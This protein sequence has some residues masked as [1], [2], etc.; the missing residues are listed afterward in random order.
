MKD[1]E[2][3]SQ[4]SQMPVESEMHVRNKKVYCS[5]LQLLLMMK[6]DNIKAKKYLLA[7][8]VVLL[9]AILKLIPITIMYGAYMTNQSTYGAV[10]Q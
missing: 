4:Q 7:S 5:K 10:R 1:C 9:V 6:I 2:S 3:Y 8:R